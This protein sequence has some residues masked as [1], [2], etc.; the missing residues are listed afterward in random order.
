MTHTT[1]QLEKMLADATPGPWVIEYK[2]GNMQL[3]AG[4]D[5]TMCDETYY[6]WVPPSHDWPIIAAAPTI[7]ADLIAARK[8]IAELEGIIA[9]IDAKAPR[10]D[11]SCAEPGITLSEAAR[12][13]LAGTT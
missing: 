7:T 5:V 13:E 1:E 10:A 11:M 9:F 6:P 3:Y 12:R 4:G 2:H 8:R